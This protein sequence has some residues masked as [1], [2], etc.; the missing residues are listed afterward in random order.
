MV[1]NISCEE[2]HGLIVTSNAPPNFECELVFDDEASWDNSN[3]FSQ[4]SQVDC[5]LDFKLCYEGAQIAASKLI[6]IC[7]FGIN[8]LFLPPA[9]YC[10]IGQHKFQNIPY[11]RRRMQNIL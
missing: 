5:R 6:V 7:A 8:K 4:K 2:P 11:L 3:V 10:C 1:P 9:D